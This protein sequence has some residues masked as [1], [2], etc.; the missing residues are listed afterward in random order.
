[1]GNR[2]LTCQ[3]DWIDDETR[4]DD[5]E[6]NDFKEYCQTQLIITYPRYVWPLPR[7]PVVDD[8]M[9]GYCCLDTP[10]GTDFESEFWGQ[11]YDSS[12]DEMKC[13]NR[14]KLHMGMSDECSNGG[15]QWF[16]TPCV[17]L[18][19]CVDARPRKD[20]D[21][22]SESFEEFVVENEIEIYNY[23]DLEQCQTARAALGF[24]VDHPND[25]EVCE[26]FNNRLC[27]RIVFLCHLCFFVINAHG[28]ASSGDL[29]F[30]DLDFLAGGVEVKFEQV[31]YTPIEYPP[32]QPL[33]Y[34]ALPLMKDTRDATADPE[35]KNS[36]DKQDA[37]EISKH[38][39]GILKGDGKEW[40]E[41]F[42]KTINSAYLKKKEACELAKKAADLAGKKWEFAKNMCN[43]IPKVVLGN[44]PMVSEKCVVKVD[45]KKLAYDVKI[46]AKNTLC[47]AKGLTGFSI[48]WIT[49]LIAKV[50]YHGVKVAHI[51]VDSVLFD[52]KLR[53]SLGKHSYQYDEVTHDN[54]RAY[55]DWYVSHILKRM[56]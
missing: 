52:M 25:H 7:D 44:S 41:E 34:K 35:T 50:G 17:T 23:T 11:H 31:T 19:R 1:L 18:H 38:T 15:G 42:H 26:E 37:L 48:G 43:I 33:E 27:E 3:L 53:D 30:R 29:F 21:G 45:F 55:G 47:D 13:Q 36:F 40:L 12:Q 10:T 32:D 14:G 46:T 24:D 8:F 2:E 56:K 49:S 5:V 28:Y 6:C 4:L 54:V 22:Y 16:R 9:P 20:E 39:L 51:T